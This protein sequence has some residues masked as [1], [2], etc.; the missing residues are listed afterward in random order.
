MK[1]KKFL[2]AFS[3]TIIFAVL[4]ILSLISYIFSHSFYDLFSAIMTAVVSIFFMVLTIIDNYYNSYYIA[5]NQKYFL[6]GANIFEDSIIIKEKR[7]IRYKKFLKDKITKS[8]YRLVYNKTLDLHFI[9]Y[10]LKSN[11]QLITIKNSSFRHS[12][13]YFDEKDRLLNTDVLIEKVGITPLKDVTHIKKYTSNNDKSI[14]LIHKEENSFIVTEYTYSINFTLK[15]R[16]VYKE[17]LPH[18]YKEYNQ[19]YFYFDNYHEAEI[20]AVRRLNAINEVY[21]LNGKPLQYFVLPRQKLGTA[22]H[23]FQTGDKKDVYWDKTSILLHE[24]IMEK[25]K[26]GEFFA[27]VIPNYAYFGKSLV[28]ET[29]WNTILNQVVY[30]NEM[31]K[32][33]IDELRLWAEESIYEF[34][35]FTILGI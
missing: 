15:I 20:F 9:V 3:F 33:I 30:E 17:M 14:L 4:S 11:F 21:T 22:Y 26:I 5:Y 7:I 27:R 28:D 35:C 18:W 19:A 29:T 13:L 8:T 34:G 25:H 32:V 16:D 12:G 1:V 10:E 6:N 2:I 23:E 31:V 24:D